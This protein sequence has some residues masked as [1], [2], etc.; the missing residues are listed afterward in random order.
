MA[1]E[2]NAI[3]ECSLLL[4]MTER[5][6]VTRSGRPMSMASLPVILKNP[7]YCGQIRWN[8]EVTEAGHEPLI[9][10]EKFE[11]VQASLKRKERHIK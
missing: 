11:G 9:S 1:F 7:F 3:S 10:H 2:L 5:G 8:G 4:K 6:L